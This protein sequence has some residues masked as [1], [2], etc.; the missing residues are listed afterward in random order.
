M[1]EEARHVDPERGAGPD[2]GDNA[3]PTVRVFISS[4]GDVSD[5]RAVTL[6]V[7]RRIQTWYQGR[8]VLVPILWEQEPLLATAGFQQE[9]D[10]RA[11][12]SATDVAVFVLWARLG[13]PLSKDFVL[14]DGRR[15]TGTEWEF[16]DAVRENREGKRDLPHILVYRKTGA[17]HIEVIDPTYE[18]RRSDFAAV[19]SFFEKHFRDATDLSFKGSYH[20]FHDASEFGR[21]LETHLLKLLTE[22]LSA[23]AA[24]RITWYGTPFRGL[25]TFEA[26]HA[27]I[28]FG[29]TR[30]IQE[31]R[32][33][34]VRQVKTGRA[35]VLILG[36]SGNGKSSLARAGL[37]PLLT[38]P[39]VVEEGLE[40]GFCRHAIVAHPAA[41]GHRDRPHLLLEAL[42]AAL[43]E[44]AALPD[45]CAHGDAAEL[46]ALFAESP[47]SAVSHVRG[48]LRRAGKN[49]AKEKDLEAP[50]PGRLVLLVDQLEE[51]FTRE[52]VS[53]ADRETFSRVLDALARSEDVWVLATLRSDFYLAFSRLPLLMALKEGKGHYDLASPDAAETAQAIRG[54]AQ[55]AGLVYETD[56]EGGRA[57]DEVLVAEATRHPDALPLLEY[58]LTLLEEKKRDNVLTFEAY[59][60]LGGIEGAIGERAEEEW[61]ELPRAAR[62][63]FPSV[64]RALVQVGSGPGATVTKRRAPWKEVVRASGAEA[65]VERF[66]RARLL[67]ADGDGEAAVVSVA[68]EALLRTWERAKDRIAAEGEL[69]RIHS[70]VRSQATRWEM[71]NQRRDLLLPPGRPLEE[72]LLLE[73]SGFDLTDQE[74]AYVAES[75]ARA[76]RAKVLR[77]VAVT[78][79]ALLGVAAGILAVFAS[80]K[81]REAETA[82]ERA[83]RER[84]AKAQ[85]LDQVLRLADAKKVRDLINEVDRLWPL[86]P[87]QVPAMAAWIERVG[88]VLEN[89]AGHVER[90]QRLRATALPYTE[91]DRQ[92]DHGEEIGRIETLRRSLDEMDTEHAALAGTTT[93]EAETRREALKD[94]EESS[95]R[96]KEQIATLEACIRERVTWRFAD[97]KDGWQHQVLVDLLADLVGLQDPARPEAGGLADVRA[98]RAFATDLRKQSLEAPAEAWAETVAAIADEETSR[99]YQG[100]RITPQLGLVPL[101]RDPD[102]GLFE[103]AHL[104]SGTVP[105][106][107]PETGHLMLKDGFAVV[108]VLLP[109]GTFRM[110]AQKEDPDAP[111]FDAGA[112]S[113]ESPVHEVTLSPFF[114]SKYELTQAQWA[115]LTGGERPSNF[116]AGERWGGHDITPRN[117]VEEVSWEDCATWLRRH[118]MALP[119]EAGWE[120]ACRAGADTPWSTGKDAAS[121]NGSANIADEYCRAHGGHDSWTYTTEVDDGHT[122]HAPVGTFEANGFGLHDM[123]GNAW[124]WCRDTYVEYP[125]EPVTDP[126]VEDERPL[127]RVLRGGGWDGAARDARSADRGRDAPG[128]RANNLGVR[129]TRAVTP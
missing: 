20:R 128:Y 40:G 26:E 66:V 99:I 45:L 106:R 16:E 110:G 15:P 57:L 113:N 52:G 29:R 111:N 38:G 91:E 88:E 70:R 18:R 3:L 107:D 19:E 21:F 83:H 34:L 17:P 28:F 61:A 69:L 120:Y 55:V 104:G 36:R 118:R 87:G 50:P 51:M 80:G 53:D 96:V 4:P 23:E 13:T 100:L 78:V 8:L 63:A 44:E 77:R 2:A 115:T 109:G 84:E 59:E 43:L 35:F 75:E 108:L 71:E 25:E 42:A 48:A 121:L 73:G 60:E 98:R 33:A 86:H 12:P 124:E 39:W 64:L 41:S 6:G 123:H 95:A 112:N 116:A 5:E 46:A 67:M 81:Q 119:T 85:A 90:M 82:A 122:V 129:P 10:R 49:L 94:L 47:R 103:F 92:L 62:E 79:I 101:G 125:S 31:V 102:S 37:L 11:P 32:Q 89:R 30:A 9:M 58:A 126:A 14:E 76:R 65:F 56:P 72:A 68:H 74:S 127:H 117:P 54:P 1:D 22:H 24:A 105:T 97:E 7:L 93:E 114:L 27:R